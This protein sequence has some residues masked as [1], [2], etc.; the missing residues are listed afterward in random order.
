MCACMCACMCGAVCV[1]HNQIPHTKL[2]HRIGRKCGRVV[3]ELVEFVSGIL[4]AMHR[5]CQL[6]VFLD[7]FFF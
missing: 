4:L 6:F 5:T 2:S 3:T 7:N 1:T